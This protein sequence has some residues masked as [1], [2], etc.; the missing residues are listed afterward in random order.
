MRLYL[1]INGFGSSVLQMLIKTSI[2]K[3]L[4][5]EIK[6]RVDEEL[7]DG[8]TVRKRP[9]KCRV[10]GCTSSKSKRNK[11]IELLHQ[12]V[13]HHR[14]KF[15]TKE[16]YDELCTMV[17]KPNG[18]TEHAEGAHDDLIFSYLWA[19]YVFYYGEELA[20]R[21]HLMKTEIYTDD[22]YDETSYNL[23]EEYDNE[24]ET[25]DN[26]VF[27]DD[28]DPSQMIVDEQMKILNSNKSISLEEF[29]KKQVE[30]EQNILNQLLQTPGGVEA[31][32]K[33]YHVDE[34]YLNNQNN[35]GFIDI[36]DDINKQFYSDIENNQ[37]NNL[38]NKALSGNLSN[39]FDK[40]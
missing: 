2:K 9:R 15:N 14:D 39:I 3:N 5:Y 7:F 20:A 18:K 27:K 25:L 12:R 35:N 22:H 30:K 8:I 34:K 32:S 21:F 36:T 31:V 37:N 38:H 23:Q 10:Y 28:D 24:Y 29:Y 33:A 6:D 40:I 11:L 16:L 13:Q 26:S 1:N 17:V 4:Y 19:L